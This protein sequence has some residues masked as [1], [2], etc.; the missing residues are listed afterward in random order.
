MRDQMPVS[1]PAD[2]EDSKSA[3]GNPPATAIENEAQRSCQLV[4]SVKLSRFGS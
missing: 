1:P 2:S 4:L 3:I